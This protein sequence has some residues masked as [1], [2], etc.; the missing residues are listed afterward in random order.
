[1]AQTQQRY[2]DTESL[3]NLHWAAIALALVTGVLHVYA[4]V[5]EG[6]VPLTLAGLG[7]FGAVAL[8]L[9]NYRRRLLYVVGVVYTGIQVPLWYVVNSP[10]FT[11]VGYV[12]KV[13]QVVLVVV[14]AYLYLT[15]K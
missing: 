5:V 15:E 7:F 4:G 6:R 9:A 2:V 3:V 12:D 14:L 13:V 1:M 11:T 10:E 8:F